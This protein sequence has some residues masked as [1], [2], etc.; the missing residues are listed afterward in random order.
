MS[1][2]QIDDRKLLELL[3]AGFGSNAAAKQ[4]DLSPIAVMDRV[5]EYLDWGILRCA[6]NNGM[7]DWKAYGRW[8]QSRKIS[9]VA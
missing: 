7:I 6:G 4:L 3:E 2:L 5:K 8:I 9:Q 1:E